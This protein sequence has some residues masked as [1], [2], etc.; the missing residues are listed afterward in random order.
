MRVVISFLLITTCAAAQMRT[1][2]FDADPKWDALNNRLVPDPPPTTKQDFGYNAS[3][4]SIGG[5]I[6]RSQTPASYAK[7]IAPKTLNDKLSA[8]GE[9]KVTANHGN[10][11]VMFG[12]FNHDSRGWR[13]PNS[14]VFRLDGNGNTYWVFFEYGTQHRMTGG[15]VTFEGKR[16]QTTKTKPFPADGTTHKWAMSYDPNGADGLGEITLKL[17]GATYRAPLEKGHKADGATFDRFGILNVQSTGEAMEASFSDLVIDG[18]KEDLSHDPKWEAR[19]NHVE[20]PDRV[21]RPFHDFGYSPTHHAGGAKAGEIG[22]TIWRAGKPCYYADD[23]GAHSLDEPLHASGKIAFTSA[24]VDSGV[25]I[26][27]F[28]AKAQAEQP[29]KESDP[30]RQILGVVIEGPS[31]VG[32]YFRPIYTDARGDGGEAKEGPLLLP[33]D[34]SHNWSLDYDPKAGRS[35]R[36]TVTLDGKSKSIDLKP[37]HRRPGVSFD[38][39][40]I[41]NL[42]NTGHYVQ[43]W[44]DDLRYT[45]TR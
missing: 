16:Y 41:F 40:G 17:D 34:A 38:H 25:Y 39:F 28:N 3:Q 37:E 31:R 27:F 42:H 9:F 44:L 23:I 19:G 7:V 4:H 21:I 35:G 10:S 13:T 33:S 5:W 26:G 20:F 14:L 30:S 8:S 11:G 15:G 1:A 6:S 36:I 18:Q 29:A 22:G 45:A 32:H 43:V 24:A 2:T 12:W